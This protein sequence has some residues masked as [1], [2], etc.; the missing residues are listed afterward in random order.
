MQESKI[1]EFQGTVNTQKNNHNQK[2]VL[3]KK[4]TSFVFNNTIPRTKQIWQKN[5]T[6]KTV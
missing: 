2:I 1:E 5:N 6:E 3:Y 4:A